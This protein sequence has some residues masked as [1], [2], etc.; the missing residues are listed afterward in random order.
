[1]FNPD[2]KSPTYTSIDYEVEAL[3][4]TAFGFPGL[5]FTG[6]LS[7]EPDY[8]L[9]NEEWYIEAASAFYA[10]GKT[11]IVYSMRCEDTVNRAI[12]CAVRA[13]VL[14]DRRLCDRIDDAAVEE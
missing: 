5:S 10:D 1:M 11:S 2:A 7:I 3:D 9:D 4:L 13:A 8:T 12:F 14:A 6:T